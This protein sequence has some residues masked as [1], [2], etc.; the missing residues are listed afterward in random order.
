MQELTRTSC[1]VVKYHQSS[2]GKGNAFPVLI[3]SIQKD[4]QVALKS[5]AG[6]YKRY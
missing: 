2:L 1:D 5:A 3:A 6:V 4:L